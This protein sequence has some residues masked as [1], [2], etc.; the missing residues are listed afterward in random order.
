MY[1]ESTHVSGARAWT[2]RFCVR[3]R[4]AF[5]LSRRV[6]RR[7]PSRDLHQCPNDYGLTRGSRCSSLFASSRFARSPSLHFKFRP[8]R[9]FPLLRPDTFSHFTENEFPFSLLRLANEL[10]GK[11]V[12]SCLTVI[13]R[14]ILGS[15]FNAYFGSICLI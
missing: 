15:A 4:A 2:P 1:S 14:R 6:N 3:W 5:S 11:H 12:S 13:H 10:C 8:R 9:S 7:K